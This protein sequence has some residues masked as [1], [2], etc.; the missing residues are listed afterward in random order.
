MK[1]FSFFSTMLVLFLSV[2]SCQGFDHTNYNDLRNAGIRIDM[3]HYDHMPPEE[4][5]RRII[6]DILE[7]EHNFGSE[8][9]DIIILGRMES[10]KY[11]NYNLSS[12]FLE[13]TKKVLG[14]EVPPPEYFKLKYIIPI[15]LKNPE[16]MSK[17]SDWETLSVFSDY[18]T[19]TNLG[20]YRTN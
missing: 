17:I 2:I 7:N 4:A 20:K 1:N 12:G 19:T 18:E 11:R 5:T 8:Q 6:E 13:F 10:L 9:Q 15:F 3:G 16:F 14:D